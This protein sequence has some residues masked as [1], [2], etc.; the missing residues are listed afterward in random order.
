MRILIVSPRL[1]WPPRDGGQVAMSRLTL[2]L[3]RGGAEVQMVSL[4]PRK[5]R[6]TPAGPV[7]IAAIDVD[8]SRFVAPALRS[9]ASETPFIVARF[10]SRAFRDA[11]VAELRRFEPD[12]VQIES[13]FLFPYVPFIRANSRA[14]VTL[15]SVNV[16]FRIW[17]GLARNA[18]S[19]LRRTAL[20]RLADS[21]HRYELAQMAGLD[22]IVP[23]SDEDRDDFRDLGCTRPMY[24]VPCGITPA[25]PQP[26]DPE[27]SR[28]GFIGSLDYLPNQNA[29][30]W[31]LDELWP[32]VLALAPEARLS[33]AGSRPPAWLVESARARGVDVLADVEDPAAFVRGV[34]VFIA[35]LF[36][37]GGMRIK[38]LEAMSLGAP[39][40][41]TTIGAGGI[42]AR[43][44]RD[45]L[46]ADDAPS[47]AGAVVRL[48]RD[49][50][51]AAEMARSARARVN[52][53]Y[54]NDALARGLI[55]FYE[56]L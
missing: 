54:E 10:F 6:G 49:R 30:R 16:E 24:V 7:P 11:L 14:L 4:N 51:A 48:S 42:D 29:V 25:D 44:G 45:L 3:A 33:I 47:F 36:E 17:E 32:Q 41:A 37:G 15:R 52:E 21:L 19:G 50:D 55:R 12:V 23:I 34:A 27:P 43:P 9:L 13:P 40:V 46:I 28:V 22:A 53:R 26:Y 39:V 20:R 38:V 1:P 8:T 31:I 2:S 35:P 56:S 5:H 18:P